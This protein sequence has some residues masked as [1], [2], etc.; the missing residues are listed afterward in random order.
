[1]TGVGLL[2]KPLFFQLKEERFESVKYRILVFLSF[3]P[4]ESWRSSSP[5]LWACKHGE[6]PHIT[7]MVN[8]RPARAWSLR[9]LWAV[10]PAKAASC[11]TFHR[12]LINICS[13]LELGFLLQMLLGLFWSAVVFHLVKHSRLGVLTA[14]HPRLHWQDSERLLWLF[15]HLTLCLRHWAES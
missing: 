13:Y 1:M 11:Q 2:D 10:A 9:H 12:N 7:R 5:L 4:L 14:W 6:H 8:H 3:L 15:L